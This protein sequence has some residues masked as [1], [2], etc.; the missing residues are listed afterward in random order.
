MTVLTRAAALCVV[1]AFLT[2]AG[3][4]PPAPTIDHVETLFCM[5]FYDPY[6]WMEAGGDEFDRWMSAQADYAR[7]KLASIPGRAALL[8][9]LHILDSGETY[10]GTVMPTGQQWIYSKLRP[11]DSV[12]KIFIRPITD[13]T[14]RVLIDPSQFDRGGLGAHIDYWS[15]APDGLHVAYG[16]SLRGSETGT[17]RV[18]S[19]D[20]RTD[21]PSQI[22]RTRYIKP[23]WIDGGD[24]ET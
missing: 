15:V 1:L 8:A 16:V 21:L 7:R 18:R 14:E 10:V 12:A 23:S 22:D 17:L 9:Q 24:A 4:P 13:G 6:F 5:K 20:S 2:A 11:T 3:P 19:L